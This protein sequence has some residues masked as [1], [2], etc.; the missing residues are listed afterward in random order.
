MYAYFE[1][2][3]I[4]HNL[5]GNLVELYLHLQTNRNEIALTRKPLRAFLR[6]AKGTISVL[7]YFLLPE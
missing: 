5:G 1:I 6:I 2:L 3:T 7:S 4:F